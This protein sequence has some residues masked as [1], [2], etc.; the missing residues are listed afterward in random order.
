MIVD[1][2][3]KHHRFVEFYFFRFPALDYLSIDCFCGF[4]WFNFIVTNIYVVLVDDQGAAGKMSA[5]E[6]QGDV[7]SQMKEQLDQLESELRAKNERMEQLEALLA[8]DDRLAQL[9]LVDSEREEELRL[10]QEVRLA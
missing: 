7:V 2:P 4:D 9:E 3:T 1:A 5:V 6:E 10:L 8:D